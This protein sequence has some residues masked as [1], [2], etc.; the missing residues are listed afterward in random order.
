MNNM[1][2]LLSPLLPVRTETSRRPQGLLQAV[3]SL[4]ETHPPLN[5]QIRPKITDHLRPDPI[6]VRPLCFAHAP[7]V[8]PVIYCTGQITIVKR[9]CRPAHIPLV[10]LSPSLNIMQHMQ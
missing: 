5:L 1:E 3:L 10:S 8:S 9:F 2:D 6:S 7:F 4:A